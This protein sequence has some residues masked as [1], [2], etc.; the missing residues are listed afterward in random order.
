MSQ[1]FSRYEIDSSRFYDEVFDENNQPRLHY[2]QLVERFSHLNHAELRARRQTTNVFFL[3]QG[4]TFTVYGAEEGIE[5]IF[6]FDLLPRIVPDSE[7]QQIEKGLEQR[8]TALNLFLQDIYHD[9]KILKDKVVPTELIL[10]S[11]NF[12]REFVGV[13]PPLGVYIHVTGTDIIRDRDGKYMVLEDNLRSPSGVSYMLQ[14]RQAMKRAFPTMFDHYKVRPIEEY[15]QE[16][17]K[18]LQE[19]SPVKQ[20]EP[21]VAVLTPGIYNSAYFEHSFLARQ[22][23]IELTEGRDL[24]VNDNK[25]YT[26]TTKGLQRV[27]VI[28]RRVDDDFLDP[29]VFRPDSMLGVAGVVNAY[30][31]GNVALA[32]AIGTGVADDKVIYSFV[33]KI[34][35]YYL[36]QEPIIENVPTYL[37]SDPTDCKYIL[38][39]LD[40]LVVKAANESGG[41]GMLIGPHATVEEREEFAAK[42]LANPRNYIAQPTISLSRHP[43]YINDTDLT[44]CHIDLRPYILYGKKITIVPG[45]LTRVALKKGSLVVNSS[46]GGGSKDTWVLYDN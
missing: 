29:L 28:Y 1:T 18:V 26:R 17:L 11:K 10:S 46:Q 23:G 6:P 7:W 33:P 44:G 30:R 41:Y 27:D 12:R 5:R 8:I 35:K 42:V 43:S 15:P 37:A 3:N 25:V 20:R 40:K 9:Q 21:N 2:K 45:G 32:N 4:I 31:M 13:N 34:I 19:I 16:L 22:M 24:V 39:N 14:N 36:D 38:E